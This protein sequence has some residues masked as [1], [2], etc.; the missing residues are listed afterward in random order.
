MRLEGVPQAQAEFVGVGRHADFFFTA[1][2]VFFCFAV[3]QTHKT[4]GQVG[5]EVFVEGVGAAAPAFQANTV[6]VSLKL[7]LMLA[8]CP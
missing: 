8:V 5:G 7:S 3:A 4:V 2:K 6:W 1:Q